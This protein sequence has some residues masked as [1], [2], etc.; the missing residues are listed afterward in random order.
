MA[1]PRIGT[2]IQTLAPAWRPGSAGADT[3]F[4]AQRRQKL[5]GMPL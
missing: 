5:T 4:P 1:E 3:A 2:V